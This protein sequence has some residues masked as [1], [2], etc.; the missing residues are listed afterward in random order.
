MK[1]VSRVLGGFAAALCLAVAVPAMATT[2]YPTTTFLNGSFDQG[3]DGFLHWQT[4]G[5]ARVIGARHV[6]VVTTASVD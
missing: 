1:Y 6:A 5:D 2:A 3:V 4:F